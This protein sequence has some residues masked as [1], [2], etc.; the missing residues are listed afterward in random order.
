MGLLNQYKDKFADRKNVSGRGWK[1]AL[2]GLGAAVL[3]FF[4]VLIVME[5]SSG[6]GESASAAINSISQIC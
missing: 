6:D 2:L 4:V 3:I 1:L 5:V